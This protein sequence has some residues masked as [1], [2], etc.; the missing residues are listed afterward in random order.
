MQVAL[1]MWLIKPVPCSLLLSPAPRTRENEVLSGS[2]NDK[3]TVLLASVTG[4]LQGGVTFGM[5]RVV[6]GTVR[7]KT[8]KGP[9]LP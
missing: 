8:H 5:F 2:F 7:D 3:N 1:L 6:L 4:A 9:P